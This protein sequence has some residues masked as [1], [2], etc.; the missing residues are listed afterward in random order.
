MA[1]VDTLYTTSARRAAGLTLA[2]G[3]ALVLAGAA[4][5]SGR[6]VRAMSGPLA[7]GGPPSVVNA[8]CHDW[9]VVSSPNVGAYSNSL[10]AVAALSGADAWAVGWYLTSSSNSNN[11]ILAEHWDGATWK[12]IATPNPAAS[13]DLSAVAAL[14]ANN[15]WAVGVLYNA[16]KKIDQTLIEHW[17]GASWSVVSSP[18]PSTTLN[19][20]NGVAAVAANDIWAV[21]TDNPGAAY[22]PL[23]EHW[24]GSAWSVTPAPTPAGNFNDLLS[25][26]A[27]SAT[28]VWAVGTG[29][30]GG[31]QPL[32]EHWDGAT[33]S[34]VTAPYP[35]GQSS[36]YF[37]SVT[38]FS[39]TNAWAVGAYEDG[40][41]AS[42]HPLI[43]HWDGAAW[44]MASLPSQGLAYESF[45]G[46]AGQ[47]NALYAVG[48][49]SAQQ[50]GPYTALVL[51]WNGVVWRVAQAPTPTMDV[52]LN[53]AAA[54][55]LNLFAV[56]TTA[57]STSAQRTLATVR[58]PAMG[59][60]CK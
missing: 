52:A 37:A 34:L 42:E 38:A 2:L 58:H 19:D 23:I 17:D 60:A 47:P 48:E 9:T 14:A 5:G 36:V 41:G 13:D 44:T 51:A 18:S 27:V 10:N 56:G 57:A 8:G 3:L 53:A 25:V 24:D 32:V 50:L 15:V 30:S 1:M 59:I 22:S 33:W 6:P 7:L 20:L 39:A 4:L 11:Q 49:A 29:G 54:Q 43:E 16:T 55:G 26:S 21:G 12:V 40:T 31:N 35:S 28:D 46:V 45:S